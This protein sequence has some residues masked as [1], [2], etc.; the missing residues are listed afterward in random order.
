MMYYDELRLVSK[1][2]SVLDVHSEKLNKVYAK[3]GVAQ[4]RKINNIM[5]PITQV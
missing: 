2:F 5:V 4:S 3:T 1:L